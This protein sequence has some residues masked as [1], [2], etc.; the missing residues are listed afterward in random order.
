MDTLIKVEDVSKTFLIKKSPKGFFSSLASLIKPYYEEHKALKKLS[1][2]I[3]KGEKVAFLGANGAGK[4]TAIKILTGILHP[5]TGNVE[6]M[7]LTPW[8]NRT[9]LSHHIGIVFGQRSQLWYHL[10]A[11]ETYRFF[12]HMYGISSFDTRLREIVNILELHELIDKPVR[13]LSLGQRM[14]CEIGAAL[15]HR[16]PILFLDEPTIGVDIDSKV[17]IRK[18]LN[19]LSSTYGTTILLT[20]HDVGD[21]E[22]VCERAI[23]LKEGKKIVDTTV[24][25]LKQGV[26]NNKRVHIKTSQEK[27]IFSMKGVK[28][29]ESARH[30]TLIE[31]NINDCPLSNALEALLSQYNV[32][33]L[34]ITGIPLEKIISTLFARGTS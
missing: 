7:G 22:M 34:S 6:V 32:T 13:Q 26:S 1:L 15:L 8:K 24:G 20:S 4:S 3:K 33:D 23:I 31:I 10:P 19:R 18:Y 28:I 9:A 17:A 14:R 25:S 21:I 16:P 30:N 27:I 12:A 11:R 2:S 5:T 29:I